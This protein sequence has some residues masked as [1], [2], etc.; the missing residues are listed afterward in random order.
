MNVQKLRS[1][2]LDA[3]LADVT[4]AN[5]ALGARVRRGRVWNKA[6]WRD[7]VDTGSAACPRPR[8][9]GTVVGYTDA[10]GKL[11]GE[12]SGRQF[13]T[14]RVTESSG[15]GWAVVEWD[16]ELGVWVSETDE[17]REARERETDEA[18]EARERETREAREREAREREAR[19]REAREREARE[20]EEERE[21]ERAARL[22]AQEREQVKKQERLESIA[23][24]RYREAASAA[25]EHAAL[26][27]GDLVDDLRDRVWDSYEFVFAGVV[28]GAGGAGSAGGA[29]CAGG[30]DVTG[31]AGGTG[32]ADVTGGARGAERADADDAPAVVKSL[33]HG[34]LNAVCRRI[35]RLDVVGEVDSILYRDDDD[36][37]SDSSESAADSSFGW[38]GHLMISRSKGRLKKLF[39][40]FPLTEGASI[41]RPTRRRMLDFVRHGDASGDARPLVYTARG[42]HAMDRLPCDEYLGAWVLTTSSFD[43]YI[44]VAR[45]HRDENPEYYSDGR[46]TD[47]GDAEHER[48]RREADFL[49][50]EMMLAFDYDC[51]SD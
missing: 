21:E 42:D 32:G 9:T 25:A 22:L 19:E 10:G 46:S 33:P 47:W 11:V 1:C 27:V 37:S 7:D 20:R 49:D 8:L 17:A 6:K 31:G 15:P 3:A 12:N 45:V 29:G 30:A 14:D 23:R 43:R 48:K 24:I 13:D 36:C 28:G 51:W 40:S 50:Y 41:D 26:G 44:A 38:L 2:E 34:L 4:V 39:R 35:A 18:R 16:F 5:V